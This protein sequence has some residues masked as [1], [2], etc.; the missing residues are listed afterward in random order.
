MSQETNRDWL[1]AARADAGRRD[2]D[3]MIETA[4]LARVRERRALHSVAAARSAPVRRGAA[5]WWRGIAFGVPVA[6]A[7]LVTVGVGVRL[8][9]PM[10]SDAGR[11]IATPFIALVGSDALATER[12]PIV[13]TSQVARTTLADY[14]LPVDPARADEPIDAEFL[15][16]RGGLVLAVRFKE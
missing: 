1:A 4:L 3:P 2:P 15:M 11:E 6:L 5:R 12:A 10:P 14:G 7:G 8:L 13:V 9:A 16:S